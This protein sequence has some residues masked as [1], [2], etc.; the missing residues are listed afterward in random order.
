MGGLG[1]LAKGRLVGEIGIAAGAVGDEG[2][3]ELAAF[4][5]ADDL[6]VM[7]QIVAG[8][9]LRIR[10]QPGGDVM[11]GRLEEGAEAK[12]AVGLAHA[13]ILSLAA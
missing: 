9:G 13:E 1:V 10:M 4:R 12:L 7:L 8:I 2:E 6:L 11:A 5:G 3:I